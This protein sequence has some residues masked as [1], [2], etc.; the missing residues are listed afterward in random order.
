[1]KKQKNI[2]PE[3]M[4]KARKA[5][6]PKLPQHILTTDKKGKWWFVDMQYLQSKDVI[7]EAC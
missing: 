2:P 1:M 6:N 4:E 3:V 5:F 7:T